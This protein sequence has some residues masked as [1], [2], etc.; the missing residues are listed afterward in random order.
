M[1]VEELMKPRY[2]VIADWPGNK[3][4]VGSILTYDDEYF[5]SQ[6]G[7]RK[8]HNQYPAI[9]KELSWYEERKVEDMPE[10]LRSIEPNTGIPVD[11]INKVE[12]WN[13]RKDRITQV[14]L[15][16]SKYPY[17]A[18]YFLPATEQEY[19]EYQQKQK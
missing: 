13:I 11:E 5:K 15:E 17:E 2:K 16:G 14:F 18:G 19:N 1:R 10:Y 9:Y 6:G 12:M 4:P 8:W 3:A 7:W